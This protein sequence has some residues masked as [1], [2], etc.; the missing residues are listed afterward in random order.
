MPGPPGFSP[1]MAGPPDAPDFKDRPL[2]GPDF[3]GAPMPPQNFAPDINLWKEKLGLSEAQISKVG[4]LLKQQ[5][6]ELEPINRQ[7]KSHREALR[8][9]VGAKASDREIS[10]LLDALSRDRENLETKGQAF[11]ERLRNLLTTD[12]RAKFILR[13]TGS[14]WME[15]DPWMRK[16]RGGEQPVSKDK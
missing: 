14:G 10:T 8:T 16:E 13:M 2:F 11:E 5:K 4:K 3:S 12:Q 6:E 1:F 7:M 15:G 9:K